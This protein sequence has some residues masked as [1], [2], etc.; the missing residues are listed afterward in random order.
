MTSINTLRNSN[1]NFI[2][3]K[4]NTISDLIILFWML[5]FWKYLLAVA[6]YSDSIDIQYNKYSIEC[7]IFAFITCWDNV[8]RL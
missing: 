7:L 2:N 5:L 3:C 6:V 4:L 8:G 1:I